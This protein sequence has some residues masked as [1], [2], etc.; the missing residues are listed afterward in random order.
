[1]VLFCPDMLKLNNRQEVESIQLTF[2]IMLQRYLQ[3]K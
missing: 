1:M 3:L 2:T